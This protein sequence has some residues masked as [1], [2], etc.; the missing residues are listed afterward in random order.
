MERGATI[1]ILIIDSSAS[2]EQEDRHNVFGV[3]SGDVQW[4]LS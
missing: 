1:I 2:V 3:P 4:R